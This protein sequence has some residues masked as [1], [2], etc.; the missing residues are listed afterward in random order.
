MIQLELDAL[1]MQPRE[2]HSWLTNSLAQMPADAIVKIRVNG[3]VSTDN[4][5]VLRAPSLR[6]H[7]PRQP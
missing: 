1:A 6:T 3:K 2:L 5:E 4:M 7:W